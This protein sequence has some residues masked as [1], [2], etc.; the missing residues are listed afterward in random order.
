MT[1]SNLSK[2]RAWAQKRDLV[3]RTSAGTQR[4]PANVVAICEPPGLEPGLGRVLVSR[5]SYDDVET[6]AGH[7][8]GTLE[9]L[10]AM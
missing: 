1:D 5:S 7:L 8:L 2:L 6:A 9:Q 4:E 3:L 10:G